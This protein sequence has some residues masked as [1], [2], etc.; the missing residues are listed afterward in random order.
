MQPPGADSGLA[1]Y[2]DSPMGVLSVRPDGAI[3]YANQA[4]GAILDVELKSLPGAELPQ[5]APLLWAGVQGVLASALPH[6][7][8]PIEH[9]GQTLSVGCLPVMSGQQVSAVLVFISPLAAGQA[10]APEP[11]SYKEVAKQLAAIM[12]SSFDGLWISDHR[13][14]VVRVNRAALRLVGLPR[15]EVEGRF[16]GD[17]LEDGNFSD[18]V[19]LEVLRRRTTITMV[20]SLKSGKKVLATGSPIFDAK[21]EIS[22]VVINDR[23]ITLLER[24]RRQIEESEAQLEH[25]RSELSMKQLKEMESDYYICQSKL[26]QKVYQEAIRVAGTNSTVLVTGESGVGKGMLAKLIHKESARGKGPFVRVD[27]AAIPSA[28]FESEMFGYA[29]GAFTGAGQRGK[30]G[31]VELAHGGTLFLDEISEIASEDQVKLL[32]FLDERCFVPVGGT[33][34]KTVE[35]RVVAATNKNLAREVKKRRFRRDLFYRFNVVPIK[36]PPL[37]ERPRDV[38]QLIRFFMR[39]IGDE[40]KIFKDIDSKAHNL[41][42]NYPFPGNVRELENIIERVLIMSQGQLIGPEDLPGEIVSESTGGLGLDIRAGQDLRRT[43]GR[44]EL[45]IIR[46]AVERFGSQ[47]RAARHLGISQSTVARK[48]L[49]GAKTDAETNQDA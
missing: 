5:M 48:L 44:M 27:C 32:R 31:Q 12:E 13:G 7:E 23:D 16:V 19:T 40:N 11:D 15:E 36:I 17:M 45:K 42:V 49:R 30:P 18:S 34:E 4:A 10:Q 26:M 39:K 2:S 8:A 9:Q 35:T 37:R 22:F 29:S 3:T 46:Q 43:V 28:L 14:V 25:F 21:G 38:V 20:Q 1:R 47:R 41:L 33:S 24:M 6:L